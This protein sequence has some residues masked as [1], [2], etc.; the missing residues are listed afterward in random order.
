MENYPFNK[1]EIGQ[2]LNKPAYIYFYK[3]KP[4]KNTPLK[5]FEKKL[6]L[7]TEKNNSELIFYCPDTETL[8]VKV[9]HF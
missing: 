2:E 4:N 1:P 3:M 9:E 7:V 5:V 6:K 8:K